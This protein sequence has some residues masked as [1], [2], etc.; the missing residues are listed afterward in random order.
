MKSMS[1]GA[2]YPDNRLRKHNRQIVGG[3]AA[4]E[5][6]QWE[7]LALYKGFTDLHHCLSFE[8]MLQNTTVSHYSQMVVEADQLTRMHVHQF[9]TRDTEH[10]SAYESANEEGSRSSC[11]RETY[12]SRSRSPHPLPLS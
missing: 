9:V 10:Y 12:T 5:G 6:Q 4:T 2:P 11:S 7:I 3:A 1:A 8:A